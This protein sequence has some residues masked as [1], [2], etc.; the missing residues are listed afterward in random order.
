[1]PEQQQ[2]NVCTSGRNRVMVPLLKKRFTVKGTE[3][4]QPMFRYRNLDSKIRG[5]YDTPYVREN[6]M[7][8]DQGIGKISIQ[9]KGKIR[10]YPASP[11]KEYIP[12]TTYETEDLSFRIV[13][14]TLEWHSSIDSLAPSL[15]NLAY[16]EKQRIFHQRMW[17]KEF[18]RKLI[19]TLLA[20]RRGL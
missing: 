17:V 3:I 5:F 15:K 16:E 14:Q 18:N 10:E 13:V 2:L 7:D 8:W 20:K 9:D 1:M 12:D 11:S 6:S 4:Y 19:Q